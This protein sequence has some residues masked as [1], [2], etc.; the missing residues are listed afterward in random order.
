MFT[1]K[2]YDRNGVELKEGDIVA[3]SNGICFKFYAEVKYLEQEAI[4]IPFNTFTFHSFVKVDNVPKEAILSTEDRYK[5]WYI[6]DNDAL[7]DENAKV[8]KNY[9]M[10]WRG[11][12]SRLNNRCFRISKQ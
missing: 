11:C 4:I 2:L 12:E 7:P 10:D 8:F 5:I 1:L 9:L 3:I 6:F